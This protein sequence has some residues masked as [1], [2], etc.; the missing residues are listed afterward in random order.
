LARAIP[1]TIV[2]LVLISKG[3]RFN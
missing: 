1:S 2:I 3:R